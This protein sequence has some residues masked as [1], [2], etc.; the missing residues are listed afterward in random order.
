METRYHLVKTGHILICNEAWFAEHNRKL[1]KSRR[2]EGNCLLYKNARNGSRS[3]L[4][5]AELIR[6]TKGQKAE[7]LRNMSGFKRHV[8]Y[9]C[10]AFP[11]PVNSPN[12]DLAENRPLCLSKILEIYI[13][14]KQWCCSLEHWFSKCNLWTSCTNVTWELVRNESSSAIRPAESEPLPMGPVNL[15]F[16]IWSQL[17]GL[18]CFSLLWS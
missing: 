16:N 4:C 10:V 14:W 18:F 7:L 1:R 5:E 11:K 6:N 9:K 2:P 12:L 15:W 17:S 8:K 13:L 3:L